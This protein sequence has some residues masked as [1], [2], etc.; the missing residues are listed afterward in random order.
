MGETVKIQAVDGHELDAYAAKPAGEPIAG[1]VVIQEI[2]G[3]NR[4]IRSVADGYAKD[5]FF[6]VAPALFDRVERGVELSYEGED[7]RKGMALLQKTDIVKALADVDAALAYTAKEIGKKVGV[8]GYCFGGLLA[9]LSAT[10]L[11]PAAAVGYYAGRIGNFAAEMPKVPVQLHF[12]KLDTHIPAEQVE[13]VHSAH[14]EVE[15]HWYEG[16]GHGFNCDMRASYNPQAAA[17]ARAR[18]LEFLKKNLL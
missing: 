11:H 5:G 13:A 18:A 8:I 3:V 9:W 14:F 6:A 15:I 10:R 12:G 1:L 2:F 4:H 17:L 16:T 7:A